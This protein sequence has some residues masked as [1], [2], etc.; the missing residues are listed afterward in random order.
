MQLPQRTF[1]PAFLP[2]GERQPLLN[3][4][5]ED[6]RTLVG[7]TVLDGTIMPRLVTIEDAS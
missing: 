6:G 4:R 1:G 2:H 5:R 3:A 7:P